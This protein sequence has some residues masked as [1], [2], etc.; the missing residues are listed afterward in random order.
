MILKDWL[1]NWGPENYEKGTVDEEVG[2]EQNLINIS[3]RTQV[4]HGS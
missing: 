3:W 1:T 4:F 2:K